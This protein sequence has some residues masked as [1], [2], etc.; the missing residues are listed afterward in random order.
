[1]ESD[2][3]VRRWWGWVGGEFGENQQRQVADEVGSLAQVL[4]VGIGV[5]GVWRIETIGVVVEGGE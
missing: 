1:V 5:E 3:S 4:G 2:S